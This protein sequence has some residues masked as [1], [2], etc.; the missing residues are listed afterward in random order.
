LLTEAAEIVESELDIGRW[1]LAWM[2][3]AVFGKP[4][5]APTDDLLVNGI[6]YGDQ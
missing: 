4:S 6:S 3:K 2:L 5:L 1:A